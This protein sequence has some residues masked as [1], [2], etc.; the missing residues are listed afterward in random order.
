M[1]FW[2]LLDGRRRAAITLTSLSTQIYNFIKLRLSLQVLSDM[3]LF[4][5]RALSGG[6]FSDTNGGM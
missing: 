4:G 6:L 5:K 1:P 2:S 3:L